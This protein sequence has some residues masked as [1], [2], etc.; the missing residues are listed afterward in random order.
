MLAGF[1]RDVA[2]AALS[3][4]FALA[5][6]EE[7]TRKHEKQLEQQVAIRK[8]KRREIDTSIAPKLTQGLVKALSSVVSNSSI[9][10][11]LLVIRWP[12]LNTRHDNSEDILATTRLTAQDETV[13][14]LFVPDY[15]SNTIQYEEFKTRLLDKRYAHGAFALSAIEEAARTALRVGPIDNEQFFLSP[16]GE[17]YR[18]IVTRHF[19][20][21]DGSRVMNMY[22]V[23]ALRVGA[24]SAQFVVV[25]LLRVAV[26]FK[27]LF[28]GGESEIA[29]ASFKRVRHDFGKVKDKL[30]RFLRQ[31]L[32]IE[33]ETHIN[34]L[35]NEDR[36]EK[37][38][39]NNLPPDKVSD[40]FGTWKVNRAKLLAIASKVR[41]TSMESQDARV[42]TEEWI[43]QLDEFTK[44]VEPLN[45][46]AGALAA[47]RIKVWFETDEMPEA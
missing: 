2:D 11:R 44:Y 6:P 40:L 15:T 43:N 41:A 17:L 5:Q 18:I 31:F 29:V 21:Y 30:E 25:S 38:H 10:Q 1:L 34:E 47:N 4:L 12:S 3:R 42:V 19:S 45:R 23:P 27:S 32:L 13:L 7:D 35:D 14:S 39:G 24:E 46:T 20:Y 9:E 26:S 16:S 37:I 36:Y 28:L 8:A 22:F 33:H